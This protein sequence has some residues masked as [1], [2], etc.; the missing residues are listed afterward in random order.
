[1][2]GLYFTL[3]LPYHSKWIWSSQHCLGCIIRHS[4]F[5]SFTT[6]CRPVHQRETSLNNVLSRDSS[7]Q[8]A[9]THR[10]FLQVPALHPPSPPHLSLPCLHPLR[11]I[12]TH[13][14]QLHPTASRRPRPCT[15]TGFMPIK[16]RPSCCLCCGWAA[17]AITALLRQKIPHPEGPRFN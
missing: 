15:L 7:L 1:M 8:L 16:V 5:W 6:T 3:L 11:W 17:S 14:C 9:L 10:V 12:A 2:W 4:Y 13:P